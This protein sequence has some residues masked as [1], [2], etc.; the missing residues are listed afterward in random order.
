MESSTK[1]ILGI[2]VIVLLG[3]PL[4][5]Q[6]AKKQPAVAPVAAPPP[7]METPLAPPPQPFQQPLA[8]P[9]PPPQEP[10]GPPPPMSLANTAWTINHPQYGAITIE[11]YPGGQ[12]QAT[13]GQIP[14]PIQ[15]TW[16]QRGNS[17]TVT[18]M[19]QTINAQV[20][21]DQVVA[22]GIAAQRIR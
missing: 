2:V 13:G 4:V 10:Q 3:L 11:L 1:F 18:A 7:P 8:Q 19:G 17:L 16:K 22:N 6:L 9:S 12:A 21:G 20:Q 14:F 5:G 15:G